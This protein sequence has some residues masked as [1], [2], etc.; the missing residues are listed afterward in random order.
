MHFNTKEKAFKTY[1]IYVC[2]CNAAYI[3]N[4]RSQLIFPIFAKNKKWLSL[5]HR[6]SLKTRDKIARGQVNKSVNKPSLY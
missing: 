6:W 1:V 2:G 4:K 3:Y 5:D